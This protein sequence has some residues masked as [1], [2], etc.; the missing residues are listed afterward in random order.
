[1]YGAPTAPATRATMRWMMGRGSPRA[2]LIYMYGML[3]V[4]GR[5]QTHSASSRDQS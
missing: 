2:A 3:P 1:M 5:P 4:S